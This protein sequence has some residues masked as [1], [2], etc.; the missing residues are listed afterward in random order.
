VLWHGRPNLNA[1]RFGLYVARDLGTANDQA[2]GF[3]ATYIIEAW[4]IGGWPA[5][6]AVSILFG[7]FLG[8]ARRRLVGS[9]A[10]PSP[11]AVLIYCFVVTL[12]WTYYKDGDILSTVVGQT[13]T[14]VYLGLLMLVTGVLGH[15]RASPDG[16]WPQDRPTGASRVDPVFAFVGR[17]SSDQGTP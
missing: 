5:T 4:L 17:T 11:A 8:W 16:T 6:L 2:T 13:R 1:R 9:V 14:A 7:A 12:G 15:H 10:I 3:P